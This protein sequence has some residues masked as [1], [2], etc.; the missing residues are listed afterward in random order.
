METENKLPEISLAQKQLQ[1]CRMNLSIVWDKIV[2]SDLCP[3]DFM[4]HNTCA[5]DG[6]F[7]DSEASKHQDHLEVCKKCW[8]NAINTFSDNTIKI[9]AGLF[10]CASCNVPLLFDK[11]TGEK[12]LI[13]HWHCPKCEKKFILSNSDGRYIFCE[14]REKKKEEKKPA[15]EETNNFADDEPDGEEPD[16]E[17]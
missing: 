2:Q 7:D 17:G 8:E 5:I 15:E 12:N 10:F 3:S 11:V 1:S 16:D 13:Q 6:E 9:A 4:L 14:E